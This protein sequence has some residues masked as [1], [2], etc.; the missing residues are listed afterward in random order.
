M[1]VVLLVAGN[2]DHVAGGVGQSF[3]EQV[4]IVSRQVVEEDGNGLGSPQPK[5]TLLNG[6]LQA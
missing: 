6:V 3:Y 2:A 1:L 4:T 5:V